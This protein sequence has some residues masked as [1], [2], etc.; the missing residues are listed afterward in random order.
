V[1]TVAVLHEALPDQVAE[2]SAEHWKGE[3]YLDETK[4]LY[5]AVGGGSVRK[6]SLAW[7]ANPFSR[8]WKNAK[9][10]EGVVGNFVGDGLTMGG[11]LVVSKAGEVVY[12]F[13]EETFGDR[14]PMEE[15]L[16]AATE[17]ASQ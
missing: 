8:I 13:Q 15:V 10:A 5:A 6:G 17:A 3:L 12:A 16:R 7:F 11:L 9:A 1:K 2:F 4:V 14:P